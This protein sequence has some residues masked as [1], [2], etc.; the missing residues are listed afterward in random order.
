MWLRL[1]RPPDAVVRHRGKQFGQAVM[2]DHEVR[3]LQQSFVAPKI[4]VKFEVDCLNS[5]CAS[6]RPL[7]KRGDY[8]S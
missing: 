7:G 2:V 5:N 8:S 1:L 6:P 3:H 4:R